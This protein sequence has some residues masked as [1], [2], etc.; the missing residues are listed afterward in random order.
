MSRPLQV[1]ELSAYIQALLTRD[2][3][4][5]KI[6]ICGEVSNLR[7]AKYTYFDLVDDEALLHCV[8][9]DRDK[10][11]L[12]PETG[13]QL[14]CT[15]N[16]TAYGKSGIYQLIVTDLQQQGRG[17][18]V[19]ALEALKEK[20]KADEL[21]D[22][23]RKKKLP[24]FPSTVGLISSTGGAVLHDFANEVN[25]RFPGVRILVDHAPVQGEGASRYLI[26][27]LDRLDAHPEVDVICL[28][29]GGGSSED[30]SVFNEEALVRRIA[31]CQKPVVTAI[32]HQV[33][34]SLSDLAAD[35]RASTPTEAAVLITP[36]RKSL[37]LQ[38]EELDSNLIL[39]AQTALL[40]RRYRLDR[41]AAL[42]ETFSPMSRLKQTGRRVSDLAEAV[43][44]SAYRQLR[45]RQRMLADRVNGL[46]QI[47]QD[48]LKPQLW[49]VENQEG[50]VLSRLELEAGKRYLLRSDSVSYRIYVEGM[51]ENESRPSI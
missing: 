27:S 29:R 8:I 9:F 1:K 15:G 17:D 10:V 5:K 18:K 49:R 39:F 4:L 43:R 7:I 30:L 45:R 33:D 2:P 35:L 13:S 37:K 25:R 38:L 6:S 24:A 12:V 3:L 47:Y 16:V 48:L 42:V 26:D 11:G 36:D 46:D 23:R 20:L 34:T 51:E 40:S 44:L 32:G 22:E 19:L 31:V 28:A 21:F 14:V 50:K 41:M